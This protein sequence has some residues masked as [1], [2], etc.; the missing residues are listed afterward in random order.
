ME[1]AEAEAEVGGARRGRGR[2]EERAGKPGM[3]DLDLLITASSTHDRFPLCWIHHMI[4]RLMAKN[5]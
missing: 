5:N 4:L 2:D 3:L 1:E